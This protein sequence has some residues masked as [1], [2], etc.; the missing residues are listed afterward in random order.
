MNAHS[1]EVDTAMRELV[2]QLRGFLTLYDD[3][4]YPDEHDVL[5]D[6]LAAYEKAIRAAEGEKDDV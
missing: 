6:C 4:R 3:D 2:E 5:R 1:P